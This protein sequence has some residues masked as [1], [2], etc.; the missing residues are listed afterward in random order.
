MQLPTFFAVLILVWNILETTVVWEWWQK[1]LL[2][3]LGQ[4]KSILHEMGNQEVDDE[5]S[6]LFLR[7]SRHHAQHCI[8]KGPRRIMKK[9]EQPLKANDSMLHP[10]RLI[11]TYND[12]INLDRIAICMAFTIIIECLHSLSC[13]FLAWSLVVPG[14]MAL[15]SICLFRILE[16]CQNVLAREY[17]FSGKKDRR[18]RSQSTH[19]TTTLFPL[20]A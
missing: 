19:T 4:T 3:C 8:P 7:L 12:L 9:G 2:V 16:T 13:N 10:P 6:S 18:Q 11:F 15:F 20:R 5:F 14:I 1:S 17:F